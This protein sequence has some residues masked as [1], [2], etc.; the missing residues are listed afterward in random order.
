MPQT[1]SRP[2]LTTRIE[3]RRSGDSLLQLKLRTKNRQTSC[4]CDVRPESEITLRVRNDGASRRLPEKQRSGRRTVRAVIPVSLAL[5]RD[6]DATDD[7]S[8]QSN[9]HS[10]ESREV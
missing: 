10:I 4:V 1:R 9:T 8:R 6:E 3:G 5:T 2:A 7:T